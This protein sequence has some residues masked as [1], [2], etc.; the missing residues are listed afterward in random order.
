MRFRKIIFII[1]VV[2]GINIIAGAYIFGDKLFGDD[3]KSKTFRCEQCNI[4]LISIDTLGA[5]HLGLYGYNR[6]TSPFLDQISRE[7]G[8]IF[9]NAISQAPWTLPSHASMFTSRYPEE[10]NIWSPVDAL[11][12]SAKTITE[13]LHE[14]SF[15]T[16]AF[17][18]GAFIQPPWGFDRGFDGFSGNSSVE[19]WDDVPK[20]FNEAVEWLREY[21]D[22]SFFLFIRSFHVH[23]PYTPAAW[24]RVVIG[25]DGEIPEVHIDNIVEVNKRKEGATTKEIERFRTAYDAEIREL[26]AALRKFF[27]ELAT[28]GILD[29]TVV[30]LTSDHGEEFGEH[31]TTGFHVALYDETI[32]VPLIF[33]LPDTKA[34]RIDKVVEIRSIPSTILDILGLSPESAFD[35]ESLFS[36]IANNGV[37]LSITGME[38]DTIFQ[39]VEK[40][41]ELLGQAGETWFPEP[42][43][44]E[45]NDF[46]SISARSK[47]WHLIYDTEGK[48]ELYDLLADPGERV[49]LYPLWSRFSVTDQKE[50]II[51]FAALGV[52]APCVEPC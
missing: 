22:E 25:E 43:E 19:N 28:L 14:N 41:Y 34:M 7:R 51:L 27:Q 23:D 30:I 9:D 6:P 1:T 15:I 20:I 26:D 52:E 5:K 8:I 3:S 18:Y 24:S 33:F 17:S 40:M 50:I 2:L 29:N 16:Q 10:L 36:D 46:S 11:P 31:G 4:I 12:S 42:R 48:R 49:N 35:T 37:A 32:H 47:R 45:W 21:R 44:E 13:V 39:N 38:R